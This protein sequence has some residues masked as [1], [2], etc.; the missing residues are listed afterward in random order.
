MLDDTSNYILASNNHEGCNNHDFEKKLYVYQKLQQTSNLF[1][2]TCEKSVNSL[3]IS[4]PQNTHKIFYSLKPREKK[5]EIYI[6]T[7]TAH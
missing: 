4:T 6:D 5:I 3:F 2:M 1:Q 7:H